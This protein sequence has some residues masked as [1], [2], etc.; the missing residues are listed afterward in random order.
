MSLYGFATDVTEDLDRATVAVTG[1]LDFDTC[2]SLSTLVSTLS[3]TD[4]I[5]VRLQGATALRVVATQPANG[6]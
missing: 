6:R 3:L 4:R 1:D 2:Q 5:L